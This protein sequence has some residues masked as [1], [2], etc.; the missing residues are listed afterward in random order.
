MLWIALEEVSYG[1][2]IFGFG[3]PAFLNALNTQGEFN[4]HNLRLWSR[5]DG[6]WHWLNVQRWFSMFWLACCTVYP[7]A[8][9]TGVWPSAWLRHSYLPVAPVG[10]GLLFVLNYLLAK[11]MALAVLPPELMPAIT[12]LKETVY[13]LLFAAFGLIEAGRTPWIRRTMR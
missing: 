12:E 2:R 10:L 11:V 9:Q 8:R 7:F 1:Q 3:T 4:L 5:E 6:L 13:G